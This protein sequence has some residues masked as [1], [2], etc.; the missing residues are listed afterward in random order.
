MDQASN[1]RVVP[2]EGNKDLP[3]FDAVVSLHQGSIRAFFASRVRD[4]S[5]V[6]D[7]AQE[8]FLIAWR[9]LAD[10]ERGRP[11]L[12]WLRGIALNVFRA[13]RRSGAR[14][15][16]VD[17]IDL[18]LDPSDDQILEV[19]SAEIVAVLKDCVSRLTPDGQELVRR[20]YAAGMSV[21]EICKA[22]G[23]KHSAATMALHRVRLS[24]RECLRRKLGLP[25]GDER[26]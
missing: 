13:H 3:S 26:P 18:L 5:T 16:V 17:D 23:T 9:R 1:V 15:A 8:T 10:F 19:E 12:P 2:G 14:I 21:A 7:L 4:P 11:I 24:L 6:D 20:R 22:S 25:E